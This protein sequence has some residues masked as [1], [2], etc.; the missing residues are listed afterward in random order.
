MEPITEA[1]WER[2]LLD[3]SLEREGKP[4]T[5]GLTMM[6]DKGMGVSAFRDILELA[7]D[8]IDFIKLG[9]GTAIL[10]PVPVLREKLNLAREHRVHLYP[11]GTF[12]EA[13]HVQGRMEH[14][15]ETLAQIGFDW[16]EISDGTILLNSA[17]RAAAINEARSHSFR[18]ITEIGK[19]K[20]GSVTP[21]SELVETFHRDRE[22]GADY[23]IVEGRESGRNIGV[24]NAEGDVDTEYAQEVHRQI[25]PRRIWWECPRSPQ[26]ITMLKL[27]GADANLGNIPAQEI[28]SVESL[29]RGLRSD[30]FFIFGNRAREESAL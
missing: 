26:Q 16:V 7:S 4:R 2:G 14:Y 27:L 24:F 21:V 20:K 22:N 19:K 3:P 11:G 28:L 15:F 13:A 6:I 8:Y 12:F 18:V 23:I 5:N 10:T 25:D 30:T 9:F 17:E 1:N 29:R